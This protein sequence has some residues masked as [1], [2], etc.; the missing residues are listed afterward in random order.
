MSLKSSMASFISSKKLT[1]NGRECDKPDR[2]VEEG[3]V[4]TCRGLGKCV[5]TEVSGTSKKG[6]IMIVMERYL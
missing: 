3:D 5:L 4:L 1:L 2:L 6:R